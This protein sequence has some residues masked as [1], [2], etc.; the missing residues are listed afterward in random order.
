MLKSLDYAI[1]GVVAEKKQGISCSK[2]FIRC[3]SYVGVIDKISSIYQ[4]VPDEIKDDIKNESSYTHLCFSLLLQVKDSE[5]WGADFG[6]QLKQFG[7]KSSEMTN[8][9]NFEIKVLDFRSQFLM[10]HKLTLPYP[11]WIERS[12][13][14]FP[15][16][17]V[18]PEFYIHPVLNEPISAELIQKKVWKNSEFL[19]SGRSLLAH[20]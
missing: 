11:K 3:L 20:N 19:Q 13:L 1:I 9:R 15:S 7:S 6:A 5:D 16:L 10:G 4:F 12:E 17:E 14:L 8:S 18:V 2:H